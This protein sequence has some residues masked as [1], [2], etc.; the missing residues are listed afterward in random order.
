MGPLLCNIF[1]T[2]I[3]LF[4]STEIESYADDNTQY[5]T[6]NCLE[7]TLQKVEKVSNTLFKC[8][9]NNYTVAN[10][11][12]CNL[13]TSTS[14]GVG[15]KIENEIIKNSLQEKLLGIVIDNRLTLEPHVGNLCKKAGQKLHAL[16]RIANYMDIIKNHSIM[17]AFILSQFSYCP[18]VWMFHSRK[19]NHRINKIHERALRIVYNDHQC[20]FEELLERDNS[21]TI[22]ERNLQKLAIEMF[23]VN[24]GLSVHLVSEHFHFAENH[25]NFRDPG[26]KFKVDHIILKHMANNLYHISDLK[27][28]IP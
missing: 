4:C 8:F 17:N 11:D 1:L 21:F 24:N 28:E 6:G 10:A 3:F 13:L 9:S 26:T 27:S 15:V 7:K 20:T 14:E 5:A 18:L 25:Y 22:H 16:A 19:L 2:D 12:K 23:K